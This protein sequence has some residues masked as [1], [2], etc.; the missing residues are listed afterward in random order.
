[1]LVAA[2]TPCRAA[3]GVCDVAEACT[4]ADPQ[5]PADDKAPSSTV[6][7]PA[8]GVCDVAEAC[9][10]TADGCPADTF[11]P[12]T[13]QCRAPTGPCDPREL[14]TGT[15]AQCP[16]DVFLASTVTCR[17]AVGVCDAPELC[18]GNAGACP[19]DLKRTAADVCRPAAGACDAPETCTQGNNSCPPDLKLTTTTICRPATDGGCDVQEVCPGNADFCPPD[20]FA[21]ANA[22]CRA[23][24]GTC[25]PQ[26]VCSGNSSLCPA[27]VGQPPS[28]CE[29][30]ACVNATTCRTTCTT[31]ADCGA[32][33]RS[34]CRAGACITARLAFLS[35]VTFSQATQLGGVAG[36]DTTCGNLAADAGL[37]GTWRAWLGG[38]PDAGV[39]VRFTRSTV[40]WV[41]PASKAVVA[42]DWNDLVDG[43]IVNAI[44]RN[45]RGVL[46][47][48]SGVWTGTDPTGAPANHCGN[49]LVNSAQGTFGN[50]GVTSSAWTVV[51]NNAPCS[52]TGN[53]RLYCFEQ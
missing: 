53:Y 48:T 26:E 15:G 2:A 47:G 10:G 14:C 7:R 4:G 29:P 51:N 38:S 27:N 46:L 43:T 11:E 6:C 13:T 5:C 9:T 36:G 21:A 28:N 30:Y 17:P 16:A 12:G 35:S 49:W 8:A 22:V 1:M 31:D 37:G 20:F 50:S 52:G 34:M 23:S 24:T 18:P 25:D 39:T 32:A 45:E 19:A 33:S 41:L 42:N 44:S 3:A 40:P